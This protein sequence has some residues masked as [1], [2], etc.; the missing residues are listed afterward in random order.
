M[1]SIKRGLVAQFSKVWVGG[2]CEIRR[3]AS[4]KLSSKQSMSFPVSM[5]FAMRRIVLMFGLVVVGVMVVEV[6]ILLLSG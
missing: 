6:F 4:E 2:N 3:S 5:K 1:N